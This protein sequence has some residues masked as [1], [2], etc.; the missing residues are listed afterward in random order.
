MIIDNNLTPYIFIEGGSI[1]EA[2]NKINL[3]QSRV[4]FTISDKGIVKGVIGDGD[5]RRWLTSQSNV[6][7]NL[8]VSSVHNTS[9]SS[10]LISDD[11]LSIEKKFINGI[12]ILPLLDRNNKIVAVAKQHSDF[13][14]IGKFKIGKK[15]PVFIIAEIGNNHNGDYNLAKKLVDE[16]VNSGADCVKFQM[17]DISSLYRKSLYRESLNIKNSNEDLGSEYV[18]DLL[19]KYQLSDDL[20]FKIFDYCHRKG[21]MPLCTPWDYKS[22]EKL[23]SYGMEGFKVASA[24]LVNHEL[25]G[26]LIN[27][28]KPLICSTG[29]SREDE[30]I[31]SVNL[32]KRAGA[33]FSLLHCNATYPAP[34]KDINLSYLKRLSEIGQCVVGYS[35]HER[36]ISVAIA[37]VAFGARIIE[38]HFSL[39][40]NMEGNDH[41]VSLLPNEFSNLVSGIREVEQSI[42]G[43][44]ARTITQGELMNRDILGKSLVINCN[45]KKGEIIQSKM[46]EIRSPGQGLAPYQK[47]DIVNKIAFHDFQSGDFFFPSDLKTEK[48]FKP[49]NFN[50]KRKW[51]IPIRFHDMEKLSSYSNVDLV[52]FHL[53]YKDLDVNIDD[54]LKKKYDMDVII[55]APELFIGDH[56][57]DLSSE[58]DEYRNHSIMELNRVVKVT[59]KIRTFFNKTSE[60]TMIVVNVGGATKNSIID[61]T[62]KSEMLA[63]IA[64]SLSQ[65]DQKNIEFIPQT[66]PPFPWHFGGQR[67]HNL[68]VDPKEVVSFC[69]KYNFRVC[70]DVSHSKLACN[71]HNWSFKEFISQVGPYSAHLHIVDAYGIDGEGVQIGQGEIDFPAMISW[72]NQYSPDSSFIPEIWQGHKDNGSGF[73]KALHHLEQWKF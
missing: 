66:M 58:D 2:L 35:S 37:S 10:S 65:I 47:K 1:L 27:T 59:R 15:Q 29:M 14:E 30:I 25:L 55:H 48:K 22:V 63:R 57:L 5:I 26:S 70:L 34:F 45:L 21:I 4:I 50:F 12:N 73:W 53:S 60:K 20:M 19:L 56:I 42:G 6:N 28:K 9:F 36:G 49:K 54:F 71:F 41:R 7:L 69:K 64:E 3:N 46:I 31:D 8:P 67:F 17:R 43:S 61:N 24:D 39:D 16:A 68:F 40:K 62:K 32:L 52:E 18:T 38:K 72:L 23:N 13:F 11:A 33:Q 44:S 51:G